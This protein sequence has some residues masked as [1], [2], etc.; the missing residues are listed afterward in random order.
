MAPVIGPRNP[1]GEKT[2][3]ASEQC[4]ANRN[5]ANQVLRAAIPDR[6]PPAGGLPGTS[7]SPG[8]HR[9]R[10]LQPC[11]GRRQDR[12]LMAKLTASEGKN[13]SARR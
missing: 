3:H 5:N 1:S 13:N 4:D 9:R 12:T 6:S 7:R 2:G 8:C 11:S 10:D